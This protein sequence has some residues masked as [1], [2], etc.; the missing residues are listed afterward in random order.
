MTDDSESMPETLPPGFT[1]DIVTLNEL[2]CFFIEGPR[3]GSPLLLLSGM[4]EVWSNYLPV[5]ERLSDAHHVFLYDLRGHGQSARCPDRR[6]RIVDYSTDAEVFIKNVIAEPC[7]VAGHSLGALI[8]VWLAA[9][10]DAPIKA[11][12][13][14]D[15]PLFIMDWGEFC[16]ED[17]WPKRV[18]EILVQ[19]SRKANQHNWSIRK[20]A[21]SLYKTVPFRV[22]PHPDRPEK[23]IIGLAKMLLRIRETDTLP[24]P[25][26]EDYARF[27]KACNKILRGEF[28]TL[29]EMGAPRVF[30]ERIA[31]EILCTDPAV[32]E[33]A[34]TSEFSLDFEHRN[35]LSRIEIPLIYWGADPD[36]IGFLDDARIAELESLVNGP[37]ESEVVHNA[38]HHI[39]GDAPEFFA[40]RLSAFFAE[41]V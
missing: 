40:R 6:Y 1:S 31:H 4:N 28:A 35:T 8:A 39:H 17:N 38:G 27:N 30:A 32:M 13:V 20:C 41:Y 26:T 16:R 18:F 3:N 5:L 25:G 29:A 14:E 15:P 2:S 19:Q 24:S 22:N 33:V 23:R 36:I 7:F 21:D 12:S 9:F 11:V 34:L 37:F 10:S